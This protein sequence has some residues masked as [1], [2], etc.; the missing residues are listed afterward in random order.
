MLMTEKANTPVDELNKILTNI[1]D[2]KSVLL[3]ISKS[4]SHEATKDKLHE[5]AE[6]KEKES[7]NLM[8]LIKASGG[9]V[10]TN[11]RITDQEALYWVSRPLTE[12]K[13]MEVLLDT[14]IHA[15]RNA[16]E[17]YDSVLDQKNLQDENREVLKKHKQEA[18][19]N[20]DYF[21]GTKQALEK[22]SR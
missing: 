18:E 6:V 16:I 13:D 9:Q 19:A 21:E 12:T 4:I 14:L 20:L 7:Q 3:D 10:E 17:D 5:F 11:E 2:Y 8:E 15:E 1:L 22:K